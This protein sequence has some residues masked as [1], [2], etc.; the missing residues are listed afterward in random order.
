MTD[1]VA[2][3][4][5]CGLG[6]RL[7]QVMAAQAAA[8]R[9]NRPP[10]FFLPRMS[11]SD[12]GSFEIV[13]NCFPALPLVETANAWIEVEEEK[14]QC[15]PDEFPS[16]MPLV[17]KGFFQNSKN[18][19]PFDT[20]AWPRLPGLPHKERTAWAVHF[21]FGDYLLLPHYHVSLAKYYGNTLETKI[22]KGSHLVLF[23][24]STERL[25]PIEKELQAQGFTT[26]IYRSN[27]TLETLHAFASCSKGAICSNSTFAWWA[28][29]FL[30]KRW[31]VPSYFPD[32]WMVDHPTPNI[33]NLPFTQ[34]IQ[35]DTIL[36]SYSLSSFSYLQ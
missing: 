20:D 16:S 36:D 14:D 6:N 24:D 23:S 32:T 19:P 9:L 3:R 21:R 11:H 34:S 29:Y 31:A 13:R 8:Q 27:D 10:V 30:W 17:V 18:F 22:P 28:S 33:L 26:E 25:I 1:W 2:P 4:L 35:L 15:L 7:F 12:H 5:R